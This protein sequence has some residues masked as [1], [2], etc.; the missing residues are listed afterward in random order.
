MKSRVPLKRIRQIVREAVARF[1]V[2]ELFLVRKRPTRQFIERFDR[3]FDPRQFVGIE[4]IA[5]QDRIQQL[6]QP[7]HLLP[8]ETFRVQRFQSATFRSG[9]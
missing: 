3:P 6:I 4:P 5:R 9:C 2:A 8:R 1:R 7:R